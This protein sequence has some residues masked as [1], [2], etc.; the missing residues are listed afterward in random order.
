MRKHLSDHGVGSEIYYPIPLHLQE[1]FAYL[2]YKK[3]DFPVSERVADE[4]LA[5]PIYPELCEE[6]IAYVCEA[7]G[8][9]YGALENARPAQC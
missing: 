1:C 2:G 6:D 8:E 5:L 9:F 4:C 7:I 3:G